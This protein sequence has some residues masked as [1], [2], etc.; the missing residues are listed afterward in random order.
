MEDYEKKGNHAKILKIEERY[1]KNGKMRK[2]M[3]NCEENGKNEE[4]YGKL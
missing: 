4:K 1:G 2:H 3:E